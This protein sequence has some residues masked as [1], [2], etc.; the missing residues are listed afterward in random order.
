MMNFKQWLS[1][2]KGIILNADIK[3]QLQSSMNKIIE[4]AKKLKQPHVYFSKE[5]EPYPNNY[6][7]TTLNFKDQ[8]TGKQRSVGISVVNNPSMKSSGKYR[9][10]KD[11]LAEIIINVAYLNEISPIEIE[12][13]VSHE[14]IHAVD[15]KSDPNSTAYN[16]KN[17]SRKDD[18]T[19][20]EYGVNPLEFDAYTGQI[21]HSIV[22]SAEK[23]KGTEREQS[24]RKYL[25]DTLRFINSPEKAMIEKSYGFVGPTDVQHQNIYQFYIKNGSLE[26]K[27]K[28]KQRIYNAVIQAKKILDS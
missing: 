20:V 26:Q 16:Q 24:L 27:R 19:E 5:D 13:L 28:I 17:I 2:N 18:E 12:R 8:Y 10:Y 25:D 23:F 4:A 9:V 21:V 14:V 3:S 6:H 1:E 15:P 22:N 7:I 11:G